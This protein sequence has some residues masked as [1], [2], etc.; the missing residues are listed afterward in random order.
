MSGINMQLECRKGSKE[1]MAMSNDFTE[2]GDDA[3]LW[4]WKAGLARS[5]T[6]MA[7]VPHD[8]NGNKTPKDTK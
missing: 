5:A 7:R 4:P 8:A 2:I 1:V 3:M 6:H